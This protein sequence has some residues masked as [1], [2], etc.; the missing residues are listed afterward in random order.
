M[1]KESLE[2][3]HVKAAASSVASAVLAI[4]VLPRTENIKG[5]YKIE[6]SPLTEEELNE[7]ARDI[8]SDPRRVKYVT[9][10]T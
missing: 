6:N 1:K 9:A 2:K 8:M 5:I 4:S 3:W 10:I 7:H